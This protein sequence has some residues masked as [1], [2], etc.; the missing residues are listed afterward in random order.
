MLWNGNIEPAQNSGRNNKDIKELEFLMQRNSEKL[1]AVLHESE[2]KTFEKYNSCVTEY[3]ILS[4][5]QAFCDGFYLGA[6]IIA[7]ALTGAEEIAEDAE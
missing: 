7:E 3:L 6:K 4:S 5:E 2:I 1:E